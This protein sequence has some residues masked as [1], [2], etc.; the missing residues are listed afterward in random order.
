MMSVSDGMRTEGE[1]TM[2]T[3]VI[4]TYA[5]TDGETIASEEMPCPDATTAILALAA[6]IN[7]GLTVSHLAASF[8]TLTVGTYQWD[9]EEES[10]VIT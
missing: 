4:H 2:Y 7:E 6:R 3:L 9:D 10:G 5:T 8:S 1:R